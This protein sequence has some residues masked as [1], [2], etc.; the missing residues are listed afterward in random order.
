LVTSVANVVESYCHDD[1][2]KE[3]LKTSY[4][5]GLKKENWF[6][7]VKQLLTPEEG[8][9]SRVLRGSAPLK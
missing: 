2:T 5:L 7:G 1:N 3:A 6:D 9:Q 8:F 4:L